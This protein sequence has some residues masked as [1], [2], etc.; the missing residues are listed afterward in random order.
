MRDGDLVDWLVQSV[1]VV[2]HFPGVSCG[3]LSVGEDE[4]A[5]QSL[6]VDP[7]KRNDWRSR[8]S[9]HACGTRRRGSLETAVLLFAQ[10]RAQIHL[11][12]ILVGGSAPSSLMRWMQSGLKT[13]RSVA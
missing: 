13:G 6:F 2:R 5:D 12:W 9:D 1:D 10:A 3:E 8:F 7:V 11:P 4:W